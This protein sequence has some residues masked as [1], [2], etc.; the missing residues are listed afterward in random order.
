MHTIYIFGLGPAHLG[1]MPKEIYDTISK[2]DTLYLRTLEHPA[3]QEL[4]KEGL[5]IVSFDDKYEAFDEDFEQVYP[6]IVE[7]L[8]HL[9]KKG[10]FIMAF[11]VIQQLLKQRSNYYWKNMKIR[12]LLVERV[13]L[14][15]YLQPLKWIPFRAFS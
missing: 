14:M 10:M 12:R 15:I 13:L 7:E 3:A 11:Q 4:K 2:Q 5:N 6:A 9:A 8:I 1:Q